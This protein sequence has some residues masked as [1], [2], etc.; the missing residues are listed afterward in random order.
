MWLAL[1]L[2]VILA[3]ERSLFRRSVEVPGE[4]ATENQNRRQMVLLTSYY[5]DRNPDRAKELRS[6]LVE[7]VDVGIFD[8]VHVLVSPGTKV[9][10]EL[11][12]RITVRVATPGSISG[13]SDRF[14]SSSNAFLYS[15]LFAH[16]DER[17]AGRIAVISNADIVWDKSALL[18]RD[19]GEVARGAPGTA[20][21]AL[22]RVNPPCPGAKKCTHF[23]C[24]PSLCSADFGSY[25]A[26]VF[27]PPMP[28]GFVRR[29]DHRQD[30]KG[31]ENIV[32]FEMARA[33]VLVT[34]PCKDVKLTHRHC[35]RDIAAYLAKPRLDDGRY[36]QVILHGPL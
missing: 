30:Q 6:A 20:A 35:V 34:N 36:E 14:N 11:E 19:R 9:P 27:V 5:E 18:M 4:K 7:N 33:R 22:S 10:E 2:V 13:M 26:F 3:T 29:V 15:D 31:A 16:A 12:G 1:W 8:E 25:D 24:K 28:P 21:Y 32:A 23:F 17:L